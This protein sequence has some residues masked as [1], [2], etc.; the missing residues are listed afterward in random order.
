MT[1][2]IKYNDHQYENNP[3]IYEFGLRL[4]SSNAKIEKFANHSEYDGKWYFLLIKEG[5][6]IYSQNGYDR[7]YGKGLLIIP[8]K[9]EGKALSLRPGFHGLLFCIPSSVIPEKWRCNPYSS[10][11]DKD[12]EMLENYYS[13][14]REVMNSPETSWSGKELFYLCSAFVSSCRQFFLSYQSFQGPRSTEILKDFLNLVDKHCA[15]ERSLGFY[16]DK[17]DISPKYLS[18][19][20]SSTSKKTAGKWIG[21]YT[22]NHAKKILTNTRMSVADVASAMDFKTASD[23]CRYFKKVSGQ[24]PHSFR[25]GKQPGPTT[26]ESY[27]RE[28]VNSL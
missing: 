21:E 26:Q 4:F 2:N 28:T 16:A 24:S 10:L 20:I 19:I 17:L 11:K 12:I 18:S 23:F 27:Q 5:Y 7:E 1:D 9:N 25:I 14:M 3:S 13:L 15:H 6:C 8:I 22:V